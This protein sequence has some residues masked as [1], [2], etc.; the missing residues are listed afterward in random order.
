MI[1]HQPDQC[2]HGMDSSSTTHSALARYPRISV[3]GRLP[4]CRDFLLRIGECHL[5]STNQALKLPCADKEIFG[6]DWCHYPLTF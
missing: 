3:I 4:V 5:T 1:D 6:T 2:R